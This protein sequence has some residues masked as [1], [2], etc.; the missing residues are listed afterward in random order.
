MLAKE[1]ISFTPNVWAEEEEVFL[2]RN[3]SFY[4]QTSTENAKDDQWNKVWLRKLTLNFALFKNNNY[5]AT[6]AFGFNSAEENPFKI[7]VNA[8]NIR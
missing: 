5:T 3:I 8:G 1:N 2:K 4:S 6:K 7:H